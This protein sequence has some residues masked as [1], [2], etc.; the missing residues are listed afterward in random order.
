MQLLGKGMTDM[1]IVTA[2]LGIHATLGFYKPWKE[3]QEKLEK[4]RWHLQKDAV[5]KI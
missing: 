1:A 2:L 5:K 4:F 3:M